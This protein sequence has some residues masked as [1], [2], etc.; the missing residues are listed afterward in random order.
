MTGVI[1]KK[2][3]WLVIIKKKVSLKPIKLILIGTWFW[4]ALTKI[5]LVACANPNSTK[6]ISTWLIQR[7]GFTK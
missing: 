7:A 5:N 3:K 4:T 2:M 1:E 6:H